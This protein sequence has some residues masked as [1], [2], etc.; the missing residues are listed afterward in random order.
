MQGWGVKNWFLVALPLGLVL[1][2]GMLIGFA[3]LFVPGGGESTIPR[4]GP[5]LRRKRE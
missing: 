5:W 4:L 2:L 1:V 3:A